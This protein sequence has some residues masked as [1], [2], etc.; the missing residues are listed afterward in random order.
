MLE[1]LE[2]EFVVTARAKGLAESTVL[3][4]HVLRNA[5]LPVISVIGYRVGFLLS[6]TIVIE[7]VFAWPGVGRLLF[8]SIGQRDYVVVQA[9]VTLGALVVVLSNLVTDIVYAYVDPRIRYG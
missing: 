4:S 2:N 8:Q 6:G 9:V 1:V 7:T 5:V 3:A